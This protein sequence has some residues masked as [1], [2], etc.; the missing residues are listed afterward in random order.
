MHI[1]ESWFHEK[2]VLVLKMNK[3]FCVDVW[4]AYSSSPKQALTNNFLFKENIITR[5]RY[6]FLDFTLKNNVK[7][8]KLSSKECFK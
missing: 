7:W 8:V 6:M 3:Q 2:T 4:Y 5:S 1:C